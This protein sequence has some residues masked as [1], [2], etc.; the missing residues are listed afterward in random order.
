MSFRFISRLYLS[1][2]GYHHAGLQRV[3][4]RGNVMTGLDC[5]FLVQSGVISNNNL[6]DT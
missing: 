4:G 5:I 1:L 2:S 6:Y 3:R